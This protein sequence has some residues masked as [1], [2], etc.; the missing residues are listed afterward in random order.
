M[1]DPERIDKIL[2]IIREEWKKYPDLRLG[3]LLIV[4]FGYPTVPDHCDIFNIED[5]IFGVKIFK[6]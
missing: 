3:Q 4:K 2:N 5:D 1:R 6:D